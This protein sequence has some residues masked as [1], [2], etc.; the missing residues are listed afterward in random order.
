ML[1]SI[2]RYFVKRTQN[3]F[4]HGYIP[5]WIMGSKNI[6]AKRKNLL[7]LSSFDYL[8]LRESMHHQFLHSFLLPRK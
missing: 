2:G 5:L 1:S 7:S 3:Y 4:Q 6:K 8:F